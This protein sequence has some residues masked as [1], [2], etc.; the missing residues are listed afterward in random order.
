MSGRIEK[1]YLPERTDNPLLTDGLE[2]DP[3]ITEEAEGA[4]GEY[5]EESTPSESGEPQHPS[6]DAINHHMQSNTEHD[7]RLSTTP[8][9]DKKQAA[10]NAAI[11]RCENISSELTKA[12]QQPI[13]LIK[14]NKVK[15][16]V[17]NT[18]YLKLSEDNHEL[19][20]E[21]LLPT[22]ISAISSASFTLQETYI[23]KAKSTPDPELT[24]TQFYKLQDY[25]INYQ[26]HF[27]YRAIKNK[28]G[29]HTYEYD[30]IINALNT[31][32]LSISEIT[33]H[34][35]EYILFIEYDIDIVSGRTHQ[36]DY[37]N[38]RDPDGRRYNEG[39]QGDHRDRLNRPYPPDDRV[40]GNKTPHNDNNDLIS[41]EKWHQRRG[42]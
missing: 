41:P 19:L 42:N 3:T 24:K 14:D 18:N 30:P 33:A 5:S 20:I 1:P 37:Y 2:P 36:S 29:T 26:N 38:N 6:K 39:W 25:I 12:L 13:D 27:F 16:E 10:I 15:G 9:P 22:L 21:T 32:K 4:T 17:N 7:S 40:R 35:S 31:L 11:K 23:P 28:D 8:D 34:I